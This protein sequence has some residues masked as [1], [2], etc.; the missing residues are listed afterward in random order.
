VRAQVEVAELDAARLGGDVGAALAALDA[1]DNGSKDGL[2]CDEAFPPGD[3]ALGAAALAAEVDG[4]AR[5]EELAAPRTVELV[6]AGGARAADVVQGALGDCHLLGALSL[7]AARPALLARL[8][9]HPPGL[10]PA[11]LLA[12]GAATVPP[13]PSY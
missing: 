7:L 3:S 6:P 5:V 10:T 11:G 12:R 1:G 8:F 9:V 4:W 13:H 2:W